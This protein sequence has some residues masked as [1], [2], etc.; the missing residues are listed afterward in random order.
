MNRFKPIIVII[1]WILVVATM[2]T[3]AFFSLQNGKEST[4]TSNK[5]T[6]VIIPNEDNVSYAGMKA[7][8]TI[9]RKTA[10]FCIYMLLGLLVFSAFYFSL[11]IWAPQLQILSFS[12]VLLYSIIDEYIYQAI[13]PGRMP[14]AL[15]IF[16]DMSGAL[17]GI[18]V[19]SLI[20]III[21]YIKKRKKEIS[22]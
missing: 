2:V 9:T 17:I 3:I 6:E 15:D 11:Q 8:T 16:I 12:L 18:I 19:L 7:L 13:T 1:S 21:K 4:Q 22:L 10:H 5:V 14:S 20:I